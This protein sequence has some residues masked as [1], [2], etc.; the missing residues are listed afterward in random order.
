MPSRKQDPQP[1]RRRFLQLGLGTGP[2]IVSLYNR[3]ALAKSCLTISANASLAADPMTSA[4]HGL[5]VCQGASPGRW[6]N[7]ESLKALFGSAGGPAFMSIFGFL[8]GASWTVETT[9]AEVLGMNGVDD[10]RQFGAHIVAAYCNA[11]KY[12][13][14]YPLTT[15]DVVEMARSIKSTGLYAVRGTSEVWGL[16]QVIQFIEQ[17]FTLD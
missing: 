1:T 2:A 9:F 11:S 6:L 8:W 3:P 13:G 5:D 4:A 14:A 16:S 10:P 12:G 7:R 15:A 17:T